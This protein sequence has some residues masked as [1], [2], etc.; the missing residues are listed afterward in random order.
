MHLRGPDNVGQQRVG[1][2]DLHGRFEQLRPIGYD[3]ASRIFAL[4]KGV[5]VPWIALQEEGVILWIDLPGW[6]IGE[7]LA[8]R[9]ARHFTGQDHTFRLSFHGKWIRLAGVDQS[10]DAIALND[11]HPFFDFLKLEWLLLLVA[12]V[13]GD[14]C[15][16]RFILA[17]YYTIFRHAHGAIAKPERCAGDR[18]AHGSDIALLPIDHQVLPPD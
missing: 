7:T 15:G 3:S 16:V 5:V 4:H 6:K 1:N 13:Q 8:H 14:P 11:Q 18:I 17:V 2:L 12:E 10:Y 9:S